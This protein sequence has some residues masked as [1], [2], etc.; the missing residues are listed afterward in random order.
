MI[1][2]DQWGKERYYL[3]D[4][5]SGIQ[6]ETSKANHDAFL[7]IWKCA[8]A[9]L[10]NDKGEKIG[11]PMIYGTGGEGHDNDKDLKELWINPTNYGYQDRKDIE[12]NI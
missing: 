7:N 1:L 11:I 9:T 4:I 12:N 3:I 2:I 10:L 6:Y 5:E 8:E